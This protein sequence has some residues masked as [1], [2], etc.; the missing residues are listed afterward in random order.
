MFWF[1]LY[2]FFALSLNFVYYLLSIVFFLIQNVKR[3]IDNNCS[4]GLFVLFCIKSV[5]WICFVFCWD[6]CIFF[7]WGKGS[8]TQGSLGFACMLCV[9]ILSNQKKFRYYLLKC[10]FFSFPSFNPFCAY[11]LLV[12]LLNNSIT[13]LLGARKL[14]IVDAISP[15][16]VIHHR[17]RI[18]AS[19]ANR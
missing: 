11:K 1:Y 8:S 18:L 6:F 7:F 9:C 5:I 4:F 14:C 19:T 3:L 10:S 2:I 15:S 17:S 16:S 13:L 12:L